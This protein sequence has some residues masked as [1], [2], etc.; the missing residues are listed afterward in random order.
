MNTGNYNDILKEWQKR[1]LYT[2][3]IFVSDGPIDPG[4]GQVLIVECYF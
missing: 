2:N 4:L 3:E 1:P